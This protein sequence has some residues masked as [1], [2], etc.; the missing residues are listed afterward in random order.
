MLTS[1]TALCKSSCTALV[2]LTIDIEET[3]GRSRGK[4]R[5]LS[6]SR[7]ETSDGGGI[8]MIL[9]KV[10]KTNV[11]G[12]NSIDSSSPVASTDR[13]TVRGSVLAFTW[14]AIKSKHEM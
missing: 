9:R 13:V 12:I 11:R 10:P 7:D 2:V 8:G 1:R 6:I 4:T 3:I 14:R 5:S